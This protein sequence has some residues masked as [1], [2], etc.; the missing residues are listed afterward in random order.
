M[1]TRDFEHIRCYAR[2]QLGKAGSH[3]MDHTDRVTRMCRVIG[4]AEHAD[5]D[6]LIPAALLHDIARPR[7]KETGLPH[8]IEGARMAEEFLSRTG[9]DRARIPAITAAIRAHRFSTGEDPETTEAKV[10]SDADKLDAMGAV[11]IARTFMRAAEHGEDIDDAIAHFHDK[12]LKLKDR[13]YTGTGLQI[14]RVRHAE[15]IA[16]LRALETEQGTTGAR[17]TGTGLTAFPGRHLPE[18]LDIAHLFSRVRAAPVDEKTGIRITRITGDENYSL[19]AAEILAGT[20]LRPH[21]HEHG[22]EIYQVIEGSGTMRTDTMTG[23]GCSWDNEFAVEKGDCFTIPEGRVHQI[24]NPGKGPLI[25]AFVC[26]PSHL[27][28]DRFFIE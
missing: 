8:E 4:E 9:Y 22:I 26:P 2:E 3:G 27:G 28:E 1:T 11:G 13:M 24:A 5:M 7:E 10:L 19:Y 16:F 20:R 25:A 12:L 15:H 21:Y 14:A 6:I 17:E 23:S 18:D